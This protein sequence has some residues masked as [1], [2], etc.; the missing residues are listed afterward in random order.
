M[1]S[2]NANFQYNAPTDFRIGQTIPDEVPDNLKVV[3]QQI[4]SAL[5]QIIFTFVNNCGVGPQNVDEWSQLAGGS[6]TLLI[7][8]LT[9]F[10]AQA[11]ENIPFGAAV[12]LVNVGGVSFVELANATNNT[13][14]A[15]GFCSL[16][17][18]IPT[19]Q[20][21]EVQL[22]AGVTEIGGLTPGASYFLSTTP[23]LLAA[24]PAVAA[25]NIEQMVGVAI[26]STALLYNCGYW[27]QH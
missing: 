9:R 8:N 19:G 4:Y 5:Q 27:I 22:L 21:G 2:S 13:K 16:G 24:T 25:G 26:N 20:I 10:Y 7:G 15:R 1:S 14:P 6:S 3:F 18:G 12:S 11:A 17:A 23:G